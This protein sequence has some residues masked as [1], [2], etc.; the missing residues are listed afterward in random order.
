MQRTAVKFNNF[1]G[2]FHTPYL[3][4]ANKVRFAP[5]LNTVKIEKRSV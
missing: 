2:A 5:Y 4:V 1:I 3:I